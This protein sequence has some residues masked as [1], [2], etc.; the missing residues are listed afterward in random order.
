[1]NDIRKQVGGIIGLVFGVII[2]AAM[3]TGNCSKSNSNNYSGDAVGLKAER[4][5]YEEN[6]RRQQESYEAQVLIK[7]YQLKQG[8]N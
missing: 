8:N 1:M 6:M 2:A 5:N 4:L 7:Q 3:M